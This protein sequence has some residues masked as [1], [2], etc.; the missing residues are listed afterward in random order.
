MVLLLAAVAALFLVLSYTHPRAR[1]ANAMGKQPPACHHL[2]DEDAV[3]MLGPE[4]KAHS[5][6]IATTSSRAQTLFDLGMLAAHGF[7][8]LEA[9]TWFQVGSGIVCV[10]ICVCVPHGVRPGQMDSCA[11]RKGG[12]WFGDGL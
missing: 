1:A 7:N 10:C 4:N 3:R 6:R 11:G 2:K 9:A 12:R 5:R 8:Q